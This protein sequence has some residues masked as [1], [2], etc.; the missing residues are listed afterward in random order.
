MARPHPELVQNDFSCKTAAQPITP[1]AE[2]QPIT[3]V[4][5]LDRS[6]SKRSNFSLVK[7]AAAEFVSQLLPY[8]R[9]RLGSFSNRIEIDPPA[10][11]SSKQT[12]LE[13]LDHKLLPIGPTPLWN[14]TASAM[15]ALR[16]EE[17]RR[18][19]LMFTDGKD[20]PTFE[21]RLAGLEDVVAQS[22]REDVMVYAIGLSTPCDASIASLTIPASAG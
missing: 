6:G 13:V 7:E 22:Q 9:A 2:L 8:D 19:V 4:V 15:D 10:F 5:M 21:G 14:A 11:T 3:I 20:N 17:G 18:V 1:S 16:R 12:L